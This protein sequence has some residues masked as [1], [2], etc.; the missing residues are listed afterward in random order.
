LEKEKL[1]Y[2]FKSSDDYVLANYFRVAERGEKAL[3]LTGPVPFN[4]VWDKTVV[5]NCS[6]CNP[7]IDHSSYWHRSEIYDFIATKSNIS[8]TPIELPLIA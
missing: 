7:T 6:D 3:G 5:V 8:P 4:L 2:V 1:I